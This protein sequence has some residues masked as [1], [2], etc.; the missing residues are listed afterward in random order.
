M[1]TAFR[2][3]NLFQNLVESCTNRFNLHAEALG[4][5][6]QTRV[7]SHL[8]SLDCTFQLIREHSVH[9]ESQSNSNI[10]DSMIQ[11][12][13]HGTKEIKKLMASVDTLIDI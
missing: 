7:E 3:Q 2:D 9:G 10:T 12:I 11:A 8:S 1:C 5:A 13:G 4:L 6:A